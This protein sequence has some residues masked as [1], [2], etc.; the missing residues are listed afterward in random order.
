MA[1]HRQSDPVRARQNAKARVAIDAKCLR[2]KALMNAAGGG[3][4]RVRSQVQI[5]AR[6][7]GEIRNELYRQT[8]TNSHF[9]REIRVIST[10]Q[11]KEHPAQ[12]FGT[13]SVNGGT[14][15]C[16]AVIAPTTHARKALCHTTALKMSA[17]LPI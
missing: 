13:I 15:A 14:K 9:L 6:D 12:G 7:A 17:S 8:R 5:Q 2:R 3:G 10:T 4:V 16:S 11:K 1:K